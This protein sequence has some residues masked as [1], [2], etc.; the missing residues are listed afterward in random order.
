MSRLPKPAS[1]L[2]SLPEHVVAA[3]AAAFAKKAKDVTVLD[4]RKGS[5]FADFFI[6]CSGQTPRQVT[7]IVDAIEAALKEVDLRPSHI[8]GYDRGEWVLMDYFDFIVHVFTPHMRTFY[9]LERLWGSAVQHDLVDESLP[10][11]KS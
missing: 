6:I 11:R 10:A 3:V 1:P 2:S 8:E 7:A 5:A 4:L 9:G